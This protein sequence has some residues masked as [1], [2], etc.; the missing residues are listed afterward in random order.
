MIEKYIQILTKFIGRD[1]VNVTLNL[2]DIFGSEEEQLQHGRKQEYQEEPSFA[3]KTIWCNC[4]AKSQCK[5]TAIL[6]LPSKQNA[7]ILFFS[8]RRSGRKIYQP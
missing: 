2:N 8:E 1:K 7:K 4:F 5:V 3:G 6:L